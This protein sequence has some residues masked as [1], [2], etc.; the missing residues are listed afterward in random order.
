VRFRDGVGGQ[1]KAGEEG[2]GVEEEGSAAASA[3]GANTAAAVPAD[4]GGGEAG[5][6]PA[7]AATAAAAAGA[8][9]GGSGVSG[10]FTL[11]DEIL[12]VLDNSGASSL[13]AREGQHYLQGIRDEICRICNLHALRTQ[14]IAKGLVLFFPPP[15][16]LHPPTFLLFCP[17][18]FFSFLSFWF[19]FFFGR[20]VLS[21]TAFRVFLEQILFKCYM[22]LRVFGGGGFFSFYSI[23]LV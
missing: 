15:I 3:V 19:F 11:A 16:H 13:L 6:A 21:P 10:S 9:G 20:Q 1:T 17:F 23:V 4:G 8:G 2:G 12:A 5:P 14:G 22:A 7:A 18:F